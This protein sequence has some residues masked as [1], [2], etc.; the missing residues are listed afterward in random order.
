MKS[1]SLAASAL[2]TA[3]MFLSP[4]G[5]LADDGAHGGK[6]GDGGHG[7]YE[8]GSGSS[9]ID[10]DH[11]GEGHGRYEEGSGSSVI[12]EDHPGEGHEYGK[13]AHEED[14][15]FSRHYKKYREKRKEGSSGLGRP[16]EKPPEAM[17]EG[18]GS[19]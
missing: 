13:D 17:D 3:V 10:E 2:F 15:W 4:T 9:V 5:L 14:G 11:P 18:S 8:E 6:G 12:G 16:E 19:R 1:I 7:R